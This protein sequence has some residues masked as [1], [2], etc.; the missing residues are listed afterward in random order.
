MEDK[1]QQ[2]TI[3]Q[4]IVSNVMKTSIL[5]GVLLTILMII[6]NIISTRHILMDNMQMMVKI[7]SQDISANLHLLADRIAN[8]S[9]EEVLTDESADIEARRN[10]LEERES[11]IEFVWL[12][13]YD[14]NGAKLFGDET[15]PQSA[16]GREQYQAMIQTDNIAIGTPLYENEIWQME[17]GGPLKRDG[18]VCAYLIGSYKYDI[19]EDVLG[20]MNVGANGSAYILDQDGMII[21]DRQTAR[22]EAHSNIYDLYGSRQNNKVFDAMLRF[23]TGAGGTMIDHSYHYVAYSPVAGTNWTMVVDAPYSDYL[24]IVVVTTVVGIVLCVLLVMWAIS[25]SGKMSSKISD[26]LALATSRMTS[27]AAGNL[28][29]PV[30]IAGTGDEA[31]V[32]TEALAETVVNIDH[33]IEELGNCLEYLSHGDYAQEVPD[34]FAGDFVVMREALERITDSLN[35]TMHKIQESSE[36]IN[37]N[38][39]ETS[40]YARR[41][42]DGSQEQEKTLNE[43]IGSVDVIIDHI[44]QIDKSASNV[45]HFAEGAQEKVDQGKA[46][47]DS[48][49]SDMENIYSNMQEIIN[50]SRMIANISEE[51]SLLSLNASIEAARAGEAGRG[52]GVVAQQI[53]ALADQ[54]A[55]ALQQTEDMIS[56]ANVSIDT[57]MKTARQ[58][59]ESFKEIYEVT[60]EFHGISN[61]IEVI[62]RKQQEAVAQVAEEIQKVL[63][64]A[65]ANQELSEKA[66]ETAARSLQQAQELEQVVEA[67]T[68]REERA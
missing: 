31:Q 56:Q 9:L 2:K 61:Q 11:R 23:E 34:S 32:M 63:E 25:Y 21:A 8:L 3:K 40:D 7:A 22:M 68:L 27:L 51:T 18:E 16:A 35:L 15:A 29:E 52:F 24:G 38:S 36:A 37:R 66:D 10:I 33:Y 13:V 48:M 1:K 67:V 43:L 45:K 12:A 60:K 19:L 54:T 30:V 65:G 28:K 47:M 53:G 6:S 14:K 17:V 46:Q 44:G 5:L 55:Q 49:M 41:L 20:N 39:S 64:V 26:S 50:I 42:Y 62:A 4:K 59:E 57:G 58:T